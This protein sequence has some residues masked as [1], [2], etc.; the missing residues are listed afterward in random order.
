MAEKLAADAGDEGHGNEHRQQDEGDGDDRAG[1]LG[2]GLL[3]SLRHGQLGF[4]VDHPLDVLDDDDGVIDHDADGEHERQQGDGVGRI[5]DGQHHG[6]RADDRH[7]HGNQRDQRRPQLAEEQEHHQSHE[8]D[9]LDQ[10]AN[11][12]F[13][14]RGDEDRGVEEHGVGEIIGEARRQGI[15]GFA[16][17]AGH[18]DGIGPRRLV[19]ADRGRGCAIEAAVAVLRSR[20]HLD[21]GDIFHPN[22]RTVGI[23]A[24]DD[25]GE[26]LRA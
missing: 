6:E 12:L 4:L 3:A 15:H 13:D 19:D 9:C 5:A 14:R 21:A 18:I 25:G 20:A 11:D 8:D 16:N 2:H 17:A 10:R 22:N 7:R 24:Q 1:N 23:G 26:F